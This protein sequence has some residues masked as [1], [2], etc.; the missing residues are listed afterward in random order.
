MAGATD[1]LSRE[2][3]LVL[4]RA[5]QPGLRIVTRHGRRQLVRRLREP[6]DGHHEL[7][8]AEIG[9]AVWQRMVADAERHGIEGRV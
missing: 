2:E 6:I 5:P 1:D 9:G 8:I 3:R 4:E 7:L